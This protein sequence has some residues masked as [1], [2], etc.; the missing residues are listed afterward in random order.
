MNLE[1]LLIACM[2]WEKCCDS[3]NCC[4]VCCIKKSKSLN[5]TGHDVYRCPPYRLQHTKFKELYEELVEYIQED[6]DEH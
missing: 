2:D 1:A 5:D 4:D 3:F 6:N